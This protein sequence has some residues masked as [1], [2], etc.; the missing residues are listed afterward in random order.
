MPPSKRIRRKA[1]GEPIRPKYVGPVLNQK[2]IGPVKPL[3][4]R[5]RQNILL[6]GRISAA[7]R[8][9]RKELG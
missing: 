8:R 5:Q 6:A 7:R 9:G 3:T 2:A 4:G 1:L